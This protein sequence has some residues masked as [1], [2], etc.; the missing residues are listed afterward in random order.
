MKKNM[1]ALMLFSAVNS[2]NAEMVAPGVELVSHKTWTT[3]NASGHV[4][5]NSVFFSSALPNNCWYYDPRNFESY[6][7]SILTNID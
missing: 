5:D 3:G 4:E 2:V 7:P 6:W 1:L